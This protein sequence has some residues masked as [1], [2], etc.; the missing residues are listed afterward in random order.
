MTGTNQRLQAVAAEALQ[1]AKFVVVAN[2]EPF[3]HVFHDGEIRCEQP[4]SGLTTALD[5]VMRAFKDNATVPIISMESARE[6]PCQGL[7]DLMTIEE[8]FGLTKG[9][10]VTLTWAPHIK[11]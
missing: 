4:A 7:A 9:L 5:P 3:S 6:H 1:G 8:E 10:P 11:L 2:R